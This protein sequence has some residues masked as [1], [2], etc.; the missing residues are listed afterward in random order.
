[1]TGSTGTPLI[2]L[3]V[4]S[5]ILFFLLAISHSSAL[6]AEHSLS[7]LDPQEHSAPLLS[8]K[9]EKSLR[10][11]ISEAEKKSFHFPTLKPLSSNRMDAGFRG[12]GSFAETDPRPWLSLFQKLARGD[13]VH[14]HVFGGSMTEGYGCRGFAKH[15]YFDS[16]RICA[17]PHR[18]VVCSYRMC[19][20]ICLYR[21]VYI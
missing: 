9:D 10:L 19:I 8:W 15:E 5:G 13:T 21:V 11:M 3:V 4:L 17:W 16:T 12:S 7:P 1:M 20:V 6:P 2:D 18:L 14:V